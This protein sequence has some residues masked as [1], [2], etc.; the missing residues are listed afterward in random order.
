MGLS[1]A[2]TLSEEIYRNSNEAYCYKISRALGQ[3]QSFP[4]YKNEENPLSKGCHIKSR[5]ETEGIVNIRLDNF[6]LDKKEFEKLTRE[7]WKYL[8]TKNNFLEF[9]KKLTGL[10][11]DEW[12]FLNCRNNIRISYLSDWQLKKYEILRENI[13]NDVKAFKEED[14]DFFKQILF[15]KSNYPKIALAIEFAKIF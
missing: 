14:K 9:E 3:V 10:D 15:K 2:S 8:G 1:L 6:I 13:I 7:N 12:C 4:C 11:N 5:T